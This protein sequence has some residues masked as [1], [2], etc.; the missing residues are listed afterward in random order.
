MRQLHL[1]TV[2]ST[3]SAVV[4]QQIHNILHSGIVCWSLA[5]VPRIRK[6]VVEKEDRGAHTDEPHTRRF[7]LGALKKVEP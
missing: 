4:L 5:E 1:L 7:S 3:Q 2:D 6:N